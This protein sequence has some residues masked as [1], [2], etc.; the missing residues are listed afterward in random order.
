[1][2]AWLAIFGLVCVIAG[3]IVAWRMAAVG[4]S[5]QASA[6]SKPGNQAPPKPVAVA[7]DPDLPPP[8]VAKV[9]DLP[10]LQPAVKNLV[11]LATRKEWLQDVE[12]ELATTL[13]RIEDRRKRA[14]RSLGSLSKAD[15]Q[16]GKQMLNLLGTG[17]DEQVGKI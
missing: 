15:F 13:D 1:K 10:P 6:P 9:P 17:V 4:G 14:A 8:Q 12:R 5:S 2:L 11:N 3:G 7:K 16:A